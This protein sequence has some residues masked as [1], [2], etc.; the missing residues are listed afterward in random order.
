MTKLNIILIYLYPFIIE[1][2][3]LGICPTAH[4][5]QKVLPSKVSWIGV[6]MKMSRY[7]QR[8][9]RINNVIED[10]SLVFMVLAFSV[11]SFIKAFGLLKKIYGNL[12]Y[13]LGSYQDNPVYWVILV[14]GSVLILISS[15][16]V[17]SK[18]FE[19]CNGTIFKKFGL[20]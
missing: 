5:V 13:L 7:N 9:E 4:T 19:W 14:T 2:G 10:I 3:I 12:P 17:A 16:I 1:L 8:L 15:I 6:E 18:L 20:T 11:I